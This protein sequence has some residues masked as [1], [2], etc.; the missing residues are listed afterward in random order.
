M[1]FPSSVDAFWSKGN[2]LILFQNEGEGLF[3]CLARL[4]G[5]LSIGSL[6]VLVGE[7]FLP[8]ADR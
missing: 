2:S 8:D 3:Y 4:P 6:P 7:H 1:D 5:G